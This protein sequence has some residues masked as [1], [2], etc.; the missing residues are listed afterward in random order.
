MISLATVATIVVLL[1]VAAL[2]ARVA[3]E[4]GL[5]PAAAVTIV[6]IAAGGILPHALTVELRPQVLAV[7]LPA[8]IFEAAWDIDAR[9]LRRV[10][11]AIV[12]LAIVGTLVT[13]VVIGSAASYTGLPVRSAL[14]L[15]AILAATDPVAVLALF[16]RLPIPRELFT[17][18][19]GESI[20]NDG[21]AAALL[22][23]LVPLS[24]VGS[25]QGAA[26]WVLLHIL[27]ICAGGI[28]VGVSVALIGNVL[29]RRLRSA[30]SHV[31]VTLGVAY[32]AYAL[33]SV[34]GTSGIF[35]SAAAGVALPAFSLRERDAE[36]VER[37]WDRAALAANAIVFLLMGLSLRIER[38]LG[39]PLL[40]SAVIAGA[41][42]SRAAFT[43]LL[44]PLPVGRAMRSGW[45]LTIAL[46]G[47]RGG[48]SV[49]LVLG[50]PAAF[51][52]RPAIVDAVFAVVFLTVV[53]QGWLLEPVLRRLNL[54]LASRAVAQPNG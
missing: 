17:I 32:G 12:V 9:V 54:D 1:G 40:L 16:R 30:W 31:V 25:L 27:V 28:V 39:E 48:L 43:Y 13:T 2:F 34:A 6:G 50:L 38:I 18:V 47:V 37:F 8:L 4:A 23:T 10:I 45:R 20:G 29:L 42:V 52:A 3:A 41:L 19:A 15:G 5:P 51:P 35:A 24:T 46:A 22:A 49:A 14:V 11:P 36:T 33:A 7:F 44:T 26:G 53:V 21:V